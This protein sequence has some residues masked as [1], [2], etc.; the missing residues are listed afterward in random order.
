MH[1]FMDFRPQAP[2]YAYAALRHRVCGAGV[3]ACV[4]NPAPHPW[5]A[6]LSARLSCQLLFLYIVNKYKRGPASAADPRAFGAF[7]FPLWNDFCSLNIQVS[8]LCSNQVI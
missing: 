1:T 4:F 6:A 3:Y 7:S 5:C 2:R 8:N